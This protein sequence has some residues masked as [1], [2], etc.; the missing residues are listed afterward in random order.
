MRYHGRTKEYALACHQ[1]EVGGNA[2]HTNKLC[3]RQ[4]QDLVGVEIG[5][6]PQFLDEKP[7][8]GTYIPKGLE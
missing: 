8:V 4:S 6:K 3:R 1:L 5:G 2:T 7:E